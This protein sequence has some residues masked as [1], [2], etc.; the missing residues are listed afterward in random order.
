[1]QFSISLSKVRIDMPQK[2]AARGR[3]K[4]TGLDDA[5]PLAAIAEMIA[6]NPGMKPTTAIKAVGI[7]DPS[8][9]RRLRDKYQQ[10]IGPKAQA[11]GRSLPRL[12]AQRP[13]NNVI[14]LRSHTNPV[15]R[16]AKLQSPLP[17]SL[18]AAPHDA[19]ED[20]PPAPEDDPAR[21]PTVAKPDL[22][23]AAYA[24]S[25]ATAKVAIHLHYKSMWYAFQWSACAYAIRNTEYTRLVLASLTDKD[26]KPRCS[27]HAD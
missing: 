4:G 5:G 6:A 13:I 19:T 16:D 22:F 25:V 3:P 27:R 17:A 1:V 11:G 20:V 9:V 23:A 14:A 10:L 24:A 12:A 2:T 8:T 21:S 7:T 15:R 18:P 26:V